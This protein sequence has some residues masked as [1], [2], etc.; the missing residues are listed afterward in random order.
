MGSVGLCLSMAMPS[1]G[2]MPEILDRVP[3]GAAM[4]VVLDN[5]GEF[6]QKAASMA[7][8]LQAGDAAMP[9]AMVGGMLQSPGLRADGEMAIAFLADENGRLD[10]EADSPPMVLLVPVTDYEQFGATFGLEADEGGIGMLEVMGESM[11]TKSVGAQWAAV[12]PSRETLDRYDGRAGQL[13]AHEQWLGTTGERIADATDLLVAVNIDSIAPMLREGVEGMKSQLEM[14]GAMMGDQAQNMGQMAE[15]VGTLSE[16]LIRDGQAA[17]MGVGLGDAGITLD[18]GA[19]FE[20]GSELGLMMD[21]RGGALELLGHMP[22]SEFLVAMAMD[23]SSPGAKAMFG[24]LAEISAELNPQQGE[25]MGMM[26]ISKMIDEQDGIAFVMGNPPA[27]IGG[28]LLTNTLQFTKTDEPELL[29]EQNGK[30][31]GEMDGMTQQGITFAT[32]F[33]RGAAQVEGVDLHR[34]G[35]KMTFDPAEPS[36]QQAQMGMM[37]V[38]GPAGGPSGFHAAV[39]NGLITTF[40]QNTPL[41]GS[42]IRAAKA[43]DGLGQS[44]AI[45]AAAGHLPENAAM[46]LFIGTGAIAQQVSGV[47]AMFGAGVDLG[48]V[49]DLSPISIGAAMQDGGGLVRLHVPADVLELTTRLAEMGQAQQGD[50]PREGG[51]PRF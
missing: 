11:Y 14:M 36:A 40:S 46:Q 47:M 32:T 26:N 44:P 30:M 39:D 15:L 37:M 25:L 35:M 1:L 48:D 2:D 6:H 28:G 13:E 31:M 7:Q 3:A 50:A 22:S 23:T 10:V 4:V 19:Q 20:P 38:F 17:I 8:Q 29:L 18:F 21:A 12:S 42:A 51:R 43:G 27:I 41:M 9:L 49:G 24:R 34:W 5:V 16:E 33:E 45:L